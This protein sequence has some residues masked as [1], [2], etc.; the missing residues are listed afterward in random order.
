MRASKASD[1]GFYLKAIHDRRDQNHDD[2]QLENRDTANARSCE[3]QATHV[4][5]AKRTIQ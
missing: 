2:A 3:I 4:I 1:G 5:T